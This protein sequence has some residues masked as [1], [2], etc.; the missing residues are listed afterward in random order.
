MKTFNTMTMKALNTVLAAA[1]DLAHN[2]PCMSRQA[3]EEFARCKEADAYRVELCGVVMQIREALKE[4]LRLAHESRIGIVDGREIRSAVK[5]G[6]QFTAPL[7]VVL[8]ESMRSTEERPEYVTHIQNMQ[9]GGMDA[10]VYFRGDAE[11]MGGKDGGRAAWRKALLNYIARCDKYDVEPF[12]DLSIQ[13]IPAGVARFH[14]QPAPNDEM[15]GQTF[16]GEAS[17]SDDRR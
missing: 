3:Q 8:H 15:Q 7:R 14:A 10:G 11:G 1:K 13:N 16:D 9:N 4:A 6:D 5:P 12:P 17:F 2:T